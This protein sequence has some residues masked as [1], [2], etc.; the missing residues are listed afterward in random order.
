MVQA[1]LQQR[2]RWELC[3]VRSLCLHRRCLG[4]ERDAVWR[5]RGL[6]CSNAWCGSA[7][8]GTEKTPLPLLLRS[9]YSV[10]SCL[11]VSYLANLCCVIQQWVDMSQYC[12]MFT[13]TDHFWTPNVQCLGHCRRT[14]DAEIQRIKQYRLDDSITL[15]FSMLGTSFINQIT[16]V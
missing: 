2:A 9:V 12:T 16:R 13:V 7:R 14:P 3:C 15:M 4:I 10:A 6:L 5:H 1:S 8:N 11:P